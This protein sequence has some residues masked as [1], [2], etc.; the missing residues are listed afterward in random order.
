MKALRHRLYSRYE[1][2]WHWLQAGS[3]VLLTMTGL[4]IHAPDSLGW[5]SF[6]SAVTLHNTLGFLLI[7]NGVLGLFYYA[8]TGAIRQYLPEPRDFLSLAAR[9]ALFYLRGMFRG[10]P[11]PLKKTAERRLNPLQQV[12]YLVILNVLLPL[13]FA[14]G[15]L[16]WGGQRFPEAVRA[17][18]GV[19]IL[20]MIHTLGAWLFASFAVMHLYLITTGQSPLANLKAMVVGYEDIDEEGKTHEFPS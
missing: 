17:I 16:M 1:R 14:T 15:L 19:P 11:H 8:T 7:A 20:A 2:I 18:G 4:A 12:T 13:Q 6:A 9:Q 10:E 5:I 3:I